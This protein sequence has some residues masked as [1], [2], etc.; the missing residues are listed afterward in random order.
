MEREPLGFDPST[1]NVARLYDYFLGGKDHFPADREAAEQI[2]RVAPEVRAAARANRAFLERAV[3]ELAAAGVTQ[4]LDLGTGLPTRRSVHEMAREV[5]PGARVVYVDRDPVVLVHG[6]AM[7]AGEGTAVVYG[8]VCKP[9]EI[10][11]SPEV[12]RTIDFGRPVA[13]LLLAVMHFVSDA[14]DPG[15]ILATLREAVAPGSHLVISHAASDAR[16]AAVR[17]GVEVYQRTTSP[18]SPRDRERVAAMFEGW[19]LVEPGLVWLPQ[20]RPAP[21]DTIDFADSPESSL[22]LCGVGRKP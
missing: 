7:L 17:K 22:A 4:F 19:E 3:H 1:P 10:L 2:L 21:A 11:R 20:W 9:G 5:A 16:A 15:R 18:L 14:D 13:I 8:D 6:R 12:L